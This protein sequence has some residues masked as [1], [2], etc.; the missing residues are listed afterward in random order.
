MIAA[1]SVKLSTRE[2]Y[3][4]RALL[5]ELLQPSTSF[6]RGHG[7][8]G[9]FSFGTQHLM[10]PFLFYLCQGGRRTLVNRP[11]RLCSPQPL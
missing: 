10:V 11:F 7:R 8:H 4:I 9:R 1:S 3:L 6:V 5:I 2:C